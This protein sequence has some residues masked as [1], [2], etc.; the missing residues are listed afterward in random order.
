MEF[1][2]LTQNDKNIIRKLTGSEQPVGFFCS[3]KDIQNHKFKE[4]KPL[5]EREM[6]IGKLKQISKPRPIQD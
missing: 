4:Q 6:L 1:K 3:R 5:T 2:D